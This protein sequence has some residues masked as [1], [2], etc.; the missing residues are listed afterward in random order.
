MPE[1]TR[2]ATSLIAIKNAYNSLR[3]EE[4]SLGECEVICTNLTYPILTS[5]N[6]T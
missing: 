1:E 6:L 2:L 4:R 5:P 3:N